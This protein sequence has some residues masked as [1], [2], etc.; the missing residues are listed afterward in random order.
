MKRGKGQLTVSSWRRGGGSKHSKRVDPKKSVLVLV[1][2]DIDNPRRAGGD[3]HV[4][5]LAEL[6]ANKGL[7]VTIVCSSHPT[8]S[9]YET[10]ETMTI[11]R[12][13][14]LEL[15][16]P[17][18]WLMLI[19]R[20]FGKFDFV[21]E[22]M[23]GANRVPF[24]APLFTAVPV[25]GFWYQD[26][27]EIIRA[28]YGRLSAFLV[29]IQSLVLRI[30][31]RC[32]I[33]CPSQ[34]SQAWLET[35]GLSPR[36]IAV[37]YASADPGRLANSSKRFSERAD[38]LVVIGNIRR[39]K[40]FE[41]AIDMLSAIRKH[42]PECRLKVIG[43]SDDEGYL[44]EL[45]SRGDREDV[46]GH[47]DFEIQISDQRKYDILASAKALVICSVKEGFGLTIVEAGLCGTPCIVNRGVPEE[48][49][50][51]GGSG[52]RVDTEIPE[53]FAE[54]YLSLAGDED[55]W[56]RLSSEA[57]RMSAAFLY[58]RM[59]VA[60]SKLVENM[61]TSTSNA[62]LRDTSNAF[63]PGKDDIPRGGD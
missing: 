29:P 47:V 51:H 58:P 37:F 42:R 16:S 19:L 21:I 11:I 18:V 41:F 24:M 8:L 17:H 9:R 13:A 40:R 2:R 52:L 35:Q 59:N 4:Q 38:L 44:R 23:I 27:R 26:N 46:R 31:A 60:M 62:L 55:Y 20:R 22:E 43:R 7:H 6:L 56:A 30:H 39:L 15:L 5:L 48:A 34:D 32:N 63:K 3:R 14:P 54:A 61:A 12:L 33:V 53:A 45:R 10:H 1:S 36:Q 25:V 50:R 57:V 28:T 49:Y